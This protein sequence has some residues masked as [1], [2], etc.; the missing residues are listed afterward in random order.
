MSI[1][2]LYVLFGEVSVQVLC[3]FLNGI[4]SSLGIESYKFLQILDIKPLLDV[5]V[6]VFS[7][8]VG[9]FAVC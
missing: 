3:P 7:H 2:H 8:Q 6:N 1:G 5:S 4:V 9:D